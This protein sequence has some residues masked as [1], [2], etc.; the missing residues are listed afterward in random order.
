M[1][2]PVYD[3]YLWGNYTMKE[4]EAPFLYI[5]RNNLTRL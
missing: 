4:P 1:I 3:V 2:N 5:I